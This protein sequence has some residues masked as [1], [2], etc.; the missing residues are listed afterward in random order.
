MP[1]VR[2]L[3]ADPNASMLAMVAE[4]LRDE[5][6]VV[7]AVH[8]GADAVRDVCT[9]TPDLLILSVWLGDMTGFEAAQRLQASGCKTKLLYLSLHEGEAFVNAAFENGA[10]GYVFKSQAGS[11]LLKAIRVVANG[12]VFRPKPTSS[13]L[14]CA[15]A[16]PA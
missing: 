1:R 14:D 15:T 10:S 16:Q 13:D 11:D 12:G 2:I 8:T 5:F 4:M 9:S 7:G 3:L 6:D